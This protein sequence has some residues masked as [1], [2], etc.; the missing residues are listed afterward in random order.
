MPAEIPPSNSSTP[1]FVLY[2]A[3]D[4]RSRLSVRLEGK[5]VW[6]T[7]AQMADLFQ[8]T[9][10]NISLHV[11]NVLEDG[12]LPEESVVKEYLTT[13]ADRKSYSTKHYSLDMI[14]AVGYRVRSARGTQFR[15][16]ATATLTEYL[17]KGFALD[18]TRLKE[19]KTL[20]GGWGADYFDELLAR[21]RD[22]CFRPLGAHARCQTFQRLVLASPN[23]PFQH[24]CLRSRHKPSAPLHFAPFTYPQN[25]RSR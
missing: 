20:G 13:A 23:R 18:D 10:Q 22:I 7:Q 15:Q 11:Q 25:T 19:A 5:T 21:I 3:P 8:S 14:I 9:K 12:E 6:L 17:T 24:P 4:G 1:G 16:W 2:E